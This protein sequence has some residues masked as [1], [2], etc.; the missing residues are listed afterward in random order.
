[1]DTRWFYV[2][3]L[4]DNGLIVIKFVRSKDN[5]ADVATKNVTAEIMDGHIDA[6]S[7]PRGYWNDSGDNGA[8]VEVLE[9]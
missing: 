3:D 9:D 4:Q 6:I 7:A 1:M 2:N 5:V 8:R